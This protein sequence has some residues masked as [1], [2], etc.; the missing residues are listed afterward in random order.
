MQQSTCGLRR[1]LEREKKGKV[2]KRNP[3]KRKR[4]K[5]GEHFENR[6]FGG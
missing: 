6:N 2:R 3:K 4:K 5:R 1:V